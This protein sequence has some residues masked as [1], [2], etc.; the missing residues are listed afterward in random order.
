L[1][2]GDGRAQAN[3]QGADAQPL[4]A[5]RWRIAAMPSGQR[6]P[7]N[8]LSGVSGKLPGVDA[9]ILINASIFGKQ[10][11]LAFEMGL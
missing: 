1:T 3:G 2:G 10:I 11:R 6:R 5:S 4:C 8:V 7:P 9:N